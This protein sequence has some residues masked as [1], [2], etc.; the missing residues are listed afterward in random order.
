M[1]VVLDLHCTGCMGAQA[2]GLL[3][4]RWGIRTI[5]IAPRIVLMLVLFPGNEVA[6]RQSKRSDSCS[7]DF[8]PSSWQGMS[9]AVGA[10]VIPLVF[11]ARRARDR[12]CLDL[13]A[14]GWPSSAGRRPSAAVVTW[15]VGADGRSAGINL[16][17]H[18]GEC[19]IAGGISGRS[20]C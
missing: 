14:R 7:Y 17:C 9:A 12:A 5:A 13:F 6:H 3:A 2:G 20:Q 11:P 1:L 8:D 16:L 15:P 4:D 10:M 18:G 19:R